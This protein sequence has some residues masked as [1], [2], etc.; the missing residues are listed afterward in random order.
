MTKRTL[1][2]AILALLCVPA[3]WAADTP[4][5]AATKS[6]EAFLVLVDEGQYD[7]SWDAA[8]KL[9]QGAVTREKWKEALTST[10][11]P[12]GKLVSRSLK[13]AKYSTTLPGA[14]DGQ[15]VVV[16]FATSFENKKEAIETVTPMLEKDGSW[17]VSGYFIR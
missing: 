8:A 17:R 4:E 13:V 9:F 12:L 5:Q 16:Q 15:Y 7:K 14:P 1:A 2:C 6:A 3:G 10:R 11:T